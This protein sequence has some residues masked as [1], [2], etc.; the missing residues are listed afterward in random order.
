MDQVKERENTSKEVE[1]V[2]GRQDSRVIC[3]GGLLGKSQLEFFGLMS[4]VE[5]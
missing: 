2:M 5:L 4:K 3:V 1:V